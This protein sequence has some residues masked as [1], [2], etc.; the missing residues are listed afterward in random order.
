M[1][2]VIM[3]HSVGS[4]RTSWKENWLSVDKVQFELFCRYLKKNKYHTHFLD[5]WYEQEDSKEKNSKDLYL[6]FDDGYLD[7]LL[8]AY[9]I[10][11]QYG[12]KG[13]IFVN[14]E[15]V[16]PGF[17]IRTLESNNGETLGFLN[18]DEICFLEQSGVFDIQSHSMSHNY[19]FCSDKVIDVHTPDNIYHW[20]GWISKPER[21]PYWQLEN[22]SSFTEY[23]YPVFE[24]YR[25]LGLRRYFPDE[26]LKEMSVSL[27]RGGKGKNEIIEACTSFL[28]DHPGR[29]ETEEEMI[30]R[31]R[32][33]LFE[34]K[35]IL[36]EKL[37]KRVDFLCWPGGGYN[38]Q[39]L[40]LAEEAGYIASTIAS[41]E[42][43]QLVDNQGKPYK[44]IVRYG[45]SSTFRK[46]RYFR[47]IRLVPSKYNRHL[48]WELKKEEK[49]PLVSFLDKTNN[50]ILRFL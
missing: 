22:Q 48:I 36:E 26:S 24:Y 14:P 39:S 47:P 15:F 20:L 32:Y 38:E 29:Y 21:K 8:V 11:K 43:K 1:R 49:R 12:I 23:G 31:F 41:R 40:Q 7:N 16:D 33:E 3:I 34:S 37:N 19:Y 2:N 4:N 44:R 5:Y 17:G 35:R 13:T 9:P 6:T 27:Y 10:M 25:A 45:M 30:S 50:F 18:W 28:K 42:N 46:G